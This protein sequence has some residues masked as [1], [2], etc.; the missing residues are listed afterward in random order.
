MNCGLKDAW[1]HTFR[2][3]TAVGGAVLEHKEADEIITRH[4]SS[5]TPENTLKFGPIHPEENRWDWKEMDSIAGYA[6]QKGVVL[7]GHTLVWHNQTPSWLFRSGSGDEPV[8]KN[9][10]FKRLE[11]HIAALTERYNDVVY[12]WDVLNEVIDVEKGDNG[13]RLSSW[14]K[15]GGR[16]IYEFAFKCMRQ[17]SPTAKLFYNDYN[18]E[19]GEKMEAT[20]RFLS[21]LL[22]SGIPVQGVGIQGHWY[23]N[24]PPE[25]TLR[26]SI[27]RYSALGLDVEFTEVDISA[28]EFNDRRD[29]A[30]YYTSIPEQIL[31][32]QA[33]RYKEL[34]LIAANY[35]AVKNITIWGIADNHTW[36]DNFPVAGRKNWPLLFDETY[37]AKEVVSTLIETGLNLSD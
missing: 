27:E 21:E 8:S 12:A 3:G 1:K 30:D 6:R 33:Q 11:D 20:V 31:R 19:E 16:E 26:T 35:P 36:L 23:Y 7:R 32:Q 37:Q 2:V 28:Y 34:F 10:L 15:I 5:I 18:I 14:Y 4:F 22:D 29:K 9:Q 17:A 24:F 13:F 25:E